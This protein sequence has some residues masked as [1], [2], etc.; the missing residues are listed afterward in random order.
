[1]SNNRLW[2]YTH[3]C[4]HPHRDIAGRLLW[5]KYI[6]TA[7]ASRLAHELVDLAVTTLP[8]KSQPRLWIIDTFSPKRLP[9]TSMAWHN[10][11]Y[12]AKS[13]TSS[14][15]ENCFNHWKK[16]LRAK[17]KRAML[18]EA[19]KLIV[20]Q[21][22]KRI[23]NDADTIQRNIEKGLFIDMRKEPPDY[24]SIP[25]KKRRSTWL[26]F[27]KENV[28]TQDVTCCAWAEAIP[29]PDKMWLLQEKV[30]K[31]D[32]EKVEDCVRIH[33]VSLR[34][35]LH[36]DVP[37]NVPPECF[38]CQT[39]LSTKCPCVGILRTLL[40]VQPDDPA[41]SLSQWLQKGGKGLLKPEIFNNRV[42]IDKDPTRFFPQYLKLTQARKLPAAQSSDTP[43]RTISAVV[44]KQDVA[45]AYDDIVTRISA[46]EIQ[47]QKGADSRLL[48]HLQDFDRVLQRFELD[49]KVT[50][51]C[52]GRSLPSRITYRQPGAA[53]GGK[54]PKKRNS[55][56]QNSSVGKHVA[57]A[58]GGQNVIII[59]NTA[60]T[61][62]FFDVPFQADDEDIAQVAS[63][64]GSARKKPPGVSKGDENDWLCR[65]CN[66]GV[67]NISD[68]VSQHC[69]GKTHV[70]NVKKWGDKP[71]SPYVCRFCNFV[72][73]TTLD[74]VD[75]AKKIREHVK[76]QSHL[77]KVTKA[78]DAP[79][80]TWLCEACNKTMSADAEV[81]NA[82]NSSHE[83]ARM[84]RLAA[85]THRPDGPTLA[86]NQRSA[87]G[88][89]DAAQQQT[90]RDADAADKG[91]NKKR[92]Q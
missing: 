51:T 25:H 16:F 70:D 69:G 1:M 4:N 71:L 54:R 48:H 5:N 66:R 28:K 7:K 92:R 20:N 40:N 90:T 39:F 81:V 43:Q 15:I 76:S 82:H 17:L 61:N 77:E 79:R 62:A 29:L 11:T 47:V 74:G 78:G 85:E 91:K 63:S 88:A 42:R 49:A 3:R 41:L 26:V 75:D 68:S 55:D 14:I 72:I 65:I 34:G 56:A 89:A 86:A 44:T 27:E 36:K 46:L 12:V 23:I 60:T 58:K 87:N 57:K 52:Q 13:K 53:A 84:V 6:S 32:R 33:V 73:P 8:P 19:I 18:I 45:A 83:H 2:L 59:T 38:T 35:F 30:V 22:E 24:G 64:A 80:R 21:M 31:G 37:E 67:K 50:V 9:A 10:F